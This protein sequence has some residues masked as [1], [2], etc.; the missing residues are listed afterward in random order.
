MQ[1]VCCVQLAF[2]RWDWHA[3][4]P[5]H[6]RKKKAGRACH[7]SSRRETLMSLCGGVCFASPQHSF[8]FGESLFECGVAGG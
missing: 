1:S 3:N 8:H 6:E 5:N 7:P 4:G 2:P